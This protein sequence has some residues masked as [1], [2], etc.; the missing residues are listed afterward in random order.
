MAKAKTFSDQ[1]R[2]AIK[3][4]P[5]SCYKLAQI[6]GISAPVFSRFLNTRAGL[7]LDAVDVLVEALGGRLVIEGAPE[8]QPAPKGQRMGTRGKSKPRQERQS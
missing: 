4:D 6:T 8:A 1:L 7:S 5:R 3:A 2:A